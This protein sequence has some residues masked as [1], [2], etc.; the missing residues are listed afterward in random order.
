MSIFA[1]AFCR[2][3]L[4]FLLNES[5]GEDFMGHRVNVCLTL[6]KTANLLS[7]LVAQFYTPA[8]Y[9]DFWQ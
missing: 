4:S 1:Q 7:K 9:E 3:I 6:Y 5:L 2:H 8:V